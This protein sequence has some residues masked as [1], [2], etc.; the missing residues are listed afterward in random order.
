[1][2]C[3]YCGST[4]LTETFNF[5]EHSCDRCGCEF[6]HDDNQYRIFEEGK[7]EKFCE[8]VL[9]EMTNTTN[10]QVGNVL[11][12]VIRECKRYGPSQLDVMLEHLKNVAETILSETQIGRRDNY[13]FGALVE[14]V[15]AFET[16]GKTLV[17]RKDLELDL[18]SFSRYIENNNFRDEFN[19]Q[20]ASNQEE[21][22]ITE[23][24][25]IDPNIE[26]PKADLYN[27]KAAKAKSEKSHKKT[28]KKY[29]K[30]GAR[31]GDK[32]MSKTKNVKE[33][34]MNDKST[35][36]KLDWDGSELP[37]VGVKTN[38]ATTNSKPH[39]EE[40]EEFEDQEVTDEVFESVDLNTL[41]KSLL[42]TKTLRQIARETDIDEQLVIEA[43][44]LGKT[45]GDLFE[46]DMTTKKTDGKEE[47]NTQSDDENADEKGE[48]AR[49][50]RAAPTDK[51]E[52]LAEELEGDQDEIDANDNDKIDGEDFDLLR[53]GKEIEEAAEE[54][55]EALSEYELKDL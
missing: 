3:P 23:R 2:Q 34:D 47:F 18:H 37:G 54:L 52:T 7:Y 44:A 45:I 21:D 25:K 55:E 13:D 42:E 8:S 22:S 11:V 12:Q 26:D 38:H 17:E 16:L 49:E 36:G 28:D 40:E 4:H 6:K 39:L 51:T 5:N 30:R 31:K 33:S 43:A 29:T 24:N 50:D 48:G 53:K 27:N 10:V 19:L 15:D 9:L 32:P 41:V 20:D 46:A 1:M 14:G 35:K